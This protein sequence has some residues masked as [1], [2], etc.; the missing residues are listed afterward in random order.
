MMKVITA[1]GL[2]DLQDLEVHDVVS[3][4]GNTRVTATEWFLNGELVRRDANINILS[5]LELGSEQESLT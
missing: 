2:I 4:E 5:G 1:K 3:I